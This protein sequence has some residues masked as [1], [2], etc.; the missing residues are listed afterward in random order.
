LTL[1]CGRPRSAAIDC[2]QTIG[3]C[4]PA[5][6]SALSARTSA[7]AHS[8][9]SGACVAAANWNSPSTVNAP[10]GGTA[11][12]RMAAFSVA[13]IV[14]FDWP[15]SGPSP[16]VTSSALAAVHACPKVS[17][18]TATPGGFGTMLPPV[19]ITTTSITPGIA[20]TV[21]RLFTRT[22]VPLI[23]VGM[24]SMVGLAFCTAWS[25][26]NFLRPVTMSSASRRPV[27]LP[28]TWYCDEGLGVTLTG[29]GKVDANAVS[30]P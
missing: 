25:I 26:V 29:S 19:G 6:I 30:S 18:I 1:F 2:W 11:S 21:P 14:S 4:S 8:T 15:L 23:C 27:R 28:M 10:S 24:R 12:G 17:A 5:Q 22:T 16:Q 9:S 3:V 13:W 7:I 20:F